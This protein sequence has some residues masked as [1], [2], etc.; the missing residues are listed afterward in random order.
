M[1]VW[2]TIKGRVVVVLV[3]VLSLS[4]M[5]G[6]WLYVLKSEESTA[7]LHD[8]LLAEQ[9]AL[10][11]RL[12]ELLPNS[13]R[14]NTI[15][16]LSTPGVRLSY[17]RAPV[18]KQGGDE[19]TRAHAFEHLLSM[20]LDRPTHETIR[21]AYSTNGQALI[22]AL[23]GRVPA[24]AHGEMDHLPSKVLGDIRPIGQLKG[25][26]QLSDGSWLRFAAPV[27]TV[28][29]FSIV[30]LGGP[31]AAILASILL[32]AGW[33]LHRWTQPLSHFVAAAERLGTDLH[34]PPLSERGPFEVRKAART[35]NLMQERIQR[36]VED[37]MAFAAAIAHDL[38]TPIT[39][40]TLRAHEIEDQPMR[41]QVLADL[42]QMKR[43]ITATL[44]FAR[45]DFSQEASE[46]F[47]IAALVQTVCDDLVDLGHVVVL[48]AP[49]EVKINSKPIGLRRAVANIIDNAVKYGG[50]IAEVELRETVASVVLTVCDRGPGIAVELKEESFRPFRRFA[51]EGAPAGTGLGLT[52]AR[53][54]ARSVGGELALNDRK[55]GGLCAT[56]LLPK[57][58]PVALVA[59]ETRYS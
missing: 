15:Q 11:A 1:Y 17:E 23:L 22:D 18:I 14:S 6:L 5:L 55:G 49:P 26:V 44:G 3:V 58:I 28:S 51:R 42:D 41:E 2:D 48:T 27:L 8:A 59:G 10:V 37:R 46:S 24:T 4:H 47:D 33:V 31:L 20:F 53:G 21:L 43:M 16:A 56:L 57:R 13:E 54:V 32:L 7:L 39:R 12:T 19:G 45:S 25:E 40:L 30:K 38:G 35:F 9:V 50:G 29:P 36:L 34:A 52:V